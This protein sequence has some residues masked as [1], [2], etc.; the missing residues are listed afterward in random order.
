MNRAL[1]MASLLLIASMW[2][3][4]QS[5][6]AAS[7]TDARCQKFLQTPLPA[8]ASTFAVPEAWPECNSPKLYWG[9]G[10]KVDYGG[11]RKCA[12]AERLAI[13]AGLEPRFSVASILGGPAMLMVLYANGEGV[14]RNIQ[15][16]G[17]FACEADVPN[18]L[19][20]IEALPSKTGTDEKKLEYCDEVLSMIEIGFCAGND[21]DIRDQHRME[22]LDRLS[23]GWS[24]EQKAALSSL[25]RAEEAYSSARAHGEINIAGT[26]RAIFGIEAETSLRNNFLAALESIEAGRL[27]NGTQDDFSRADA[28]LNL[29]YRKAI[30]DAE[31]KKSDYGAVQ[32]DGIRESERSWLKY[33]DAWIAFAKLRYPKVGADAWLTLLTN[34]RIAVLKDTECEIGIDNPACAGQDDEHPPRPLP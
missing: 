11:A 14:E 5:E 26:M 9:I 24:Q 8:E 33:R 3:M 27:P 18:A 6:N 2:A 10:I 25:I 31:S 12:W 32:P 4:G 30:S 21:K 15:F 7:L 28:E 1:L 22:K 23:S 17:R 19:K 13:K 29:I 34:D 16:A 20:D